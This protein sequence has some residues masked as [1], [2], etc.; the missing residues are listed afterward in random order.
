MRCNHCQTL[1]FEAEIVMEGHTEQTLFQCPVC[2][3]VSLSFRRVG[4]RESGLPSGPTR[5]K[6][7]FAVREHEDT[8]FSAVV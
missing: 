5:G 1:M 7:G 8:E 3:R 6:S 4:A 2:N